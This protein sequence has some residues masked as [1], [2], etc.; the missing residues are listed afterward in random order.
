[1]RADRV[2]AA[3][4]ARVVDRADFWRLQLDKRLA[5]VVVSEYAEAVKRGRKR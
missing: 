3:L 1:M 2:E 5:R 4:L